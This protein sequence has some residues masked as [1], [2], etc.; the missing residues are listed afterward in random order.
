MVT[1]K[2]SFTYPPTSAAT[3]G[4]SRKSVLCS[5]IFTRMV[6]NRIVYSLLSL[7][8]TVK[9]EMKLLTGNK[10]L[11]IFHTENAERTPCAACL[12]VRNKCE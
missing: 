5:T 11:P 6:T 8:K 7:E 9:D 4:T 1:F 12:N 3:V 10:G 2:A